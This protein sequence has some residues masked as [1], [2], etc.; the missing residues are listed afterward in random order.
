M[1]LKEIFDYIYFISN[2][3][4]VG[5]AFNI[6]KFNIVLKAVDLQFFKKKYGLPENYQV[7][8][9]LSNISY[10]V[11]NQI[12]D[13]L[14]HLKV[15]MGDNVTP[16]LIVNTDGYATLP[17]N[18]IHCSYLLYT[19]N[20]ESNTILVCTDAEWSNIVSSTLK[21]PSKENPICNFTGGKIRFRPKN[22]G[23]VDF[24]Y[25]R[26]PLPAHYDY[27]ISANLEHIYLPPNTTHTLLP[28]EEGSAGQTT[29][30]V[31]SLSRELEWGNDLHLD[32]CN[33]IL[34]LIGIN[35]R[36]SDLAQWSESKLKNGE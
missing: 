30:T 16:K 10:E 36:E 27:Y 35:L 1:T 3:E 21:K 6:D 5:N 23:Y 25:L 28:N 34:S 12:T 29:G 20:D 22:I 4:Q 7:G 14:S 33:F 24:A 2:K 18:Y 9:P 19:E 13:D 32:I 31:T 15:I 17:D 26:L 8:Q 11:T